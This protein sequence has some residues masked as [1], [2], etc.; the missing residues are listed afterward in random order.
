MREIDERLKLGT[1]CGWFG[2]SRQSYYQCEWSL[3][4][5][6][7]DSGLVLDEVKNIRR[8]H[9]RIGVRKL[10]E[11]LEPFLGENGIKMGRDALFDLLSLHGMLVRKRKRHVRT[12][13]SHHWLKKYPN[14]VS[15]FVPTGPNQLWVSDITYWKAS[16]MELFLSLVTDAYSRK[17]VGYHAA[18]TLH[19]CETLKAL[20]MALREL[21]GSFQSHFQLVHHS[22]RGVQY[23]AH[24]YVSLLK[25]KG[26]AISMT[27]SGDPLE[28]AIA[29]RVNGIIKEEYLL[30]Y[31]CHGV[32]HA[33]RK[34]DEVIWLYNNERP[35]GSIGNLT[36]EMAHN[37]CHQIEDGK[38]KRLWKNYYV[39]DL[40]L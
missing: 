23:C 11:L 32:E 17:I 40:S 2:I 4:K 21:R 9:P 33:R 14:L 22:D 8:R 1:L 29:E 6:V 10:R 36:P 30:N 16:G 19:G 7:F 20:K 18:E 25:K 5:E 31:Q 15:G 38:I 28:N 39:K 37:N 27:Q 13:Q 35:H 12:T 24:P 34:L 26:I 3:S